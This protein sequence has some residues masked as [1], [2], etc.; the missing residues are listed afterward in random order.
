MNWSASDFVVHIDEA[1]TGS[2]QHDVRDAVENIRGVRQASINPARP[3]LM[4]VEFHPETVQSYDIMRTLGSRG[5]H[6]ERVS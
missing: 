5:L 6:V 1:L 3:H 4:R 2:Q